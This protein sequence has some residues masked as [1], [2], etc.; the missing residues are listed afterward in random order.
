MADFLNMLKG[1]QL[2]S[3]SENFDYV[4]ATEDFIALKLFPMA[5]TDNL[6]LAIVQLTEGGKVPVMALVHALDTE[7][8]IGDRPNY[9]RIKAE[10]LLVKE[11]LNQGEALRKFLDDTGLAASESAVL[12]AIFNDVNN[13][14]SRVLTRFEV[15][16]MELISTGKIV[17]KEN[18]YEATIDYE[19]PEKNKMAFQ[20]WENPE[21]SILSDIMTA[22]ATARNKL[23]RLIVNDTVMGYMLKNTEIKNICNS[24]SPVQFLTENWLKTYV[25]N[26]FGIAVT[27]SNKTFKLNALDET[28]YKFMPDDKIAF[29]GTEDV[30]GNT[31]VTTTPEEDYGIAAQ[32][33][34]FVAITQYKT[35]DPAGIWTK[36]SA[37][38]L[39]CP[40]DSA[41]LYPCT[42]S[43]GV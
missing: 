17:I 42:L 15:M 25:L 24:Y 34:G 6:K 43:E 20:G 9:T 32:T 12:Q 27:V 8:R 21:H 1:E 41:L 33:N 30:V 22:Q 26:T 29:I 39:P 16:G 18:G 36:A 7:A 19:V 38:A 23:K 35:T 3:L 28:E 13:L 4:T 5:K 14:I 40:S 10:L 11:K 2:V 37:V 31:F